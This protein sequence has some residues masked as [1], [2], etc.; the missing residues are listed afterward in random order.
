MSK[1]PKA[2]SIK[3]K[4]VVLNRDERYKQGF[5]RPVNKKKCLNREG[6]CV[7]RSSLEM[8]TMIHLDK[9]ENVLEWSSESTIIPYENPVTGKMARYFVDF[10]IKVNT[11]SGPKKFLVEVKPESQTVLREYSNNAKKS[12]KMYSAMQFAIN[13]AKWDAAKKYCELK[14]MSFKIMTEKDIGKLTTI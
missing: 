6:F 1:Q 9:N 2:F 10:Y 11:A 4:D 14:G 5:F 7:Y 13:S 12:T 3:N 8:Q